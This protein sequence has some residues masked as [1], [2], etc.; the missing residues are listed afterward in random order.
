[1]TALCAQ[2]MPTT[3]WRFSGTFTKAFP[4]LLFLAGAIVNTTAYWSLAPVVVFLI[5]L[6][7]VLG[8][9]WL[10]DNKGR[11]ERHAVLLVFVIC[12]FWAGI[13]ASFVE[14]FGKASQDPDSTYFHDL[15]IDKEIKPI[16]DAVD[17]RPEDES[18][19]VWRLA[20]DVFSVSLLQNAGAI[21]VWRVA[22]DLFGTI[23][24]GEGRYIGVTLNIVF[25]ALTAAMGIK[26]V[27]AI[28]GDDQW[29][30][31]RFT[32]LF[33][34]CGMFWLFGSLH[35]RDAMALFCVTF[36]ALPWV[37]FLVAPTRARLVWL[38]AATA[39]AF[40]LFGLVRTEFFFVP[41]A[42]ILAGVAAK[43]VGTRRSATLRAWPYAA[44]MGLLVAALGSALIVF[45][46][47]FDSVAT[48][49][50]AREKIY[51]DVSAKE[52]GADS[53]GNQLIL[54]QPGPLRAVFG[55]A[56]L[57]I[58]PIPFWGGALSSSAYHVYKSLHVLF[59]YFV[60]PLFALGVWRLIRFRGLRSPPLLF[61]AFSFIGFAASIGY[62][63]LETRH[64]GAFLVLL[65]ALC[66]LPDSR[67]YA[68]KR[69]YKLFLGS[70]LTFI[71]PLHLT[72]LLYKAIV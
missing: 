10:F 29:R 8:G 16:E 46:Q 36:L 9:M 48:L 5:A 2:A 44:A 54:S 34:A 56:Y 1:M 52:G 27:R 23:G 20:Y 59:M 51:S 72:W 28:F 13:S 7:A 26:M 40:T 38:A 50:S 64:I 15:V 62:T 6:S 41:L 35:I 25:V 31:R 60:L 19:S 43:V 66:V 30:I 21:L 61:L 53:L 11:E 71:V 4:L 55:T 39:I 37:H 67:V 33:S 57:L 45:P 63:S 58:S 68:D 3:P 22:Y 47:V 69:S 24:L 17:V 14:V 32:L 49:L 70:L 18:F 12:F 42:M 65:L